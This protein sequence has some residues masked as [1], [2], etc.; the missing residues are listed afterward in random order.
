MSAWD[1][2]GAGIEIHV[3]LIIKLTVMT[4]T[5]F[6]HQIAVTKCQDTSS[7]AVGGFQYSTVIPSLRQLIGDS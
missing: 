7:A 5:D 6:V 3:R 4:I 1:A 2:S